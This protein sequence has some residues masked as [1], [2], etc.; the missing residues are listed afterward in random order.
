MFDLQNENLRYN[1]KTFPIDFHAIAVRP[2]RAHA[3]PSPCLAHRPAPPLQSRTRANGAALAQD[4]FVEF[5]A[6]LK[7]ATSLQVLNYAHLHYPH[8]PEVIDLTESSDDEPD[9]A[10]VDSGDTQE[11]PDSDAETDMYGETDMYWNNNVI[12]VD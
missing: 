11:L 2:P 1:P 10:S 7:E 4:T 6:V 9:D 5:G 3:S 8:G 12:T